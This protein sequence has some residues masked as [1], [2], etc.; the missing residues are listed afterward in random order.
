MYS[1]FSRK[2]R[3]VSQTGTITFLNVLDFDFQIPPMLVGWRT[4]GRATGWILQEA[5]VVMELEG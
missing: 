2:Y 1:Q 4:K 5:V 3:F